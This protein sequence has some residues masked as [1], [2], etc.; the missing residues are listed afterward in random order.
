M[1]QVRFLVVLMMLGLAASV[2]A[3]HVLAV[4]DGEAT[5]VV[6]AAREMS[7][8]IDRDGKRQVVHARRFAFGEGGEYLPYLVTISHLEVKRSALGMKGARINREFHLYCVLE[9]AY[10][11]GDVY[12]VVITKDEIGGSGIF[13]FEVGDLD[14]RVP[15]PFNVVVPTDQRAI[16]GHFRLYLFSAGK[17]LL[18]S[19]MPKA[20][21]ESALEKMVTE[22]IRGVADAEATP[23]TGPQPEFPRALKREKIDGSATL[24]FAVDARGKV[25]DATVARASR[26]EFGEAA[27]AVIGEWRF[28]PKVV[29][30][31][32]VAC[33][34]DMPFE[35]SAHSR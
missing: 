19:R 30:G 27:L 4:K 22:R 35:F 1:N 13:L 23:L 29:G 6:V 15:R 11:L 32:P 28:V 8:L 21:I 16:P 10:R 9:T 31:H 7:P 26:P 20:V 24:T 34:V 5:W 14:P 3:Q 2:R 17:E 18:Q 25:S 12:M 33:R